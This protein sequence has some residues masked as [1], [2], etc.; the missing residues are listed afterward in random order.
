MPPA[1]LRRASFEH[2]TPLA[3]DVRLACV[4]TI[5]VD[6]P[7]V[8]REVRLHRELETRHAHKVTT[9]EFRQTFIAM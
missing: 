8:S 5:A 7:P 3:I 9:F 6:E 4:T 1:R 2:G